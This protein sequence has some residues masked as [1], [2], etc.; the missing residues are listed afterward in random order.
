MKAF[1]ASFGTFLQKLAVFISSNQK[2]VK[3]F[4]YVQEAG[5]RNI[6]FATNFQTKRFRHPD[7]AF[8]MNL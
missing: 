1:F 6:V 2:R 7:I 5:G 8:F 4:H 3:I